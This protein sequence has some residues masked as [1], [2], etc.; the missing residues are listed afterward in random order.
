MINDRFRQ[1]Y[2]EMSGATSS[3]IL[4]IKMKAESLEHE[5]N[6]VSPSR[7]IAIALAKLEEAVMWAVKAVT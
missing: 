3:L 2:R 7:E 5:F 4:A 1:N 6:R